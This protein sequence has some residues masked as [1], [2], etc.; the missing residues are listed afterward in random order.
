[1]SES[2]TLAT[3]N[4][5]LVTP[6]PAAA[7]NPFFIKDRVR[8]MF[9][10]LNGSAANYGVAILSSS[11]TGSGRRRGKEEG[12]CVNAERSQSF[13]HQGQ[14]P[15]DSTQ[16]QTCRTKRCRNPFFIKDR[17]RTELNSPDKVNWAMI[18]S[19]SFLHQG[20]GPDSVS[21]SSSQAMGFDVAILSS[22]RTGSGPGA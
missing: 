12:E 19:Q 8:T 15:D 9:A 5:S 16:S 2:S 18:E 11:R 1:M 17:V 20:Q 3:N 22:S 6:G 13:L 4:S 21:G 7:C 10:G 14:G